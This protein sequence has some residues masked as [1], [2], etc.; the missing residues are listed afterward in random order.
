ML[1]RQC[2]VCRQ[3][4]RSSLCTIS[5]EDRELVFIKSNIFIPEGSRCCKDHLHAGRLHIGALNEIR[6]FNITQRKFSSVDT[7]TW[8]SKFRDHYNSIR[9]FD[10]DLPFIMSDFDCYNLTGISKLNFE[11]LTEMLNDSKIKHSSNR[12]L[13]NA[14]GL[15]LTKLRLGIS[16]K[17]LTTIFQFSNPKAVSRTLAAVREAMLLNFVPYY[18]GFNHISRQDVINNHS[19]P[20]ATRLLTEQPN[21]AVLVI[22]GTYLYV[23]VR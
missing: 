10:F 19:S 12:S 17:V 6:P 13:R 14:V 3:L 22:D 16:N 23:Q 5:E 20:L 15:F 2:S 4:S 8:L 21:T 7:I 1:C 9:Y 11:H 18:L